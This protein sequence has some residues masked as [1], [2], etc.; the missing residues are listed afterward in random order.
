MWKKD[1]AS[2]NLEALFS[3]ELNIVVD[4]TIVCTPWREY[5]KTK[6]TILALSYR[7]TIFCISMKNDW[8]YISNRIKAIRNVIP[9]SHPLC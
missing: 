9:W 7:E 6:V 3:V 1:Y 4:I 8:I 2:I 5:I